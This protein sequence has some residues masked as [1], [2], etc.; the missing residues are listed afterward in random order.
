[1]PYGVTSRIPAPAPQPRSK[2]ITVSAPPLFDGDPK[3]YD[4]FITAVRIIFNADPDSY[5]DE[6]ARVWYALSY[7]NKGIAAIWTR[8]LIEHINK[9]DYMITT[10]TTFETEL[11]KIF[12]GSYKK[13]DA[14]CALIN[15]RQDTKSVEEFF[16]EFEEHLAESGFNDETALY[17]LNDNLNQAIVS[18]IYSQADVPT[19][20]TGWKEVA[21]RLD[22]QYHERLLRVGKTRFNTI[23][24]T[25]TT[26]PQ[27]YFNTPTPTPSAAD[28]I[29]GLQPGLGTPMDIGCQYTATPT[30][31][32]VSN[33]A[34]VR[35]Y[36]CQ[37]FGHMGRSCPLP[38]PTCEQ[39]ATRQTISTTAP[40]RPRTNIRQLFSDLSADER[41]ELVRFISEQGSASAPVPSEDHIV[42]P[43]HQGTTEGIE[44]FPTADE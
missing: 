18:K 20:Y 3:N 40:S 38:N 27:L 21:I 10:F 2:K 42:M 8:R 24:P 43:P 5:H 12:G 30:L 6:R 35:C 9:G 29:P 22:R 26:R 11:K 39:K 41:F 32:T 15:L 28:P 14:Q 34:H 36:N 16:V 7:M 17:L 23:A 4:T 37:A 13:A 44:D 33:M 31:A 1:M 19:T 25:S